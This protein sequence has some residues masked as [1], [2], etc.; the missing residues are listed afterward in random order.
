[1]RQ[2]K[3]RWEEH[4]T[5]CVAFCFGR[6]VDTLGELDMSAAT[7]RW[8]CPLDLLG[9]LRRLKL[10]QLFAVVSVPDEV[11]WVSGLG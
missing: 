4:D 5:P 1:M 6:W 7:R 2:A 3:L 11:H 10:L 9:S 8:P